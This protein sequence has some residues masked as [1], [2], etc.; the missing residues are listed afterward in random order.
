MSSI[1]ITGIKGIPEVRRGANLAHIIIE[2]A[3]NQGLPLKNGDIVVVTSKII[4]KAEDRIIKISEIKPSRI[5]IRLSRILRINPRK[6]EII[7]SEAKRIVRMARGRIIVETRHGFI[8]ANGGIDQSNVD[9][10]LLSL[11]PEDSDSSARKILN[12]IKKESGVDVAVIVTDTFGRPWR[13]GQT[14]VAIGVAGISPLRSYAGQ[15]D[16]YG[17][18][19]K[20]TNIAI[21][22]EIASASELVMGKIERVPVAIVRGLKY[23]FARGNIQHLIRKT[24]KDLFK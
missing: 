14:N 24:S 2:S 11:L 9:S 15:K 23:D 7:L 10:G 21:A 12:G 18:A 20:V 19:L 13:E 3:V 17:Y 1:L 4:S 16:T 22:D 8:C 5:A 6:V